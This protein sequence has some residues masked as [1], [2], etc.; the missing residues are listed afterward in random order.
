MCVMLLYEHIFITGGLEMIIVVAHTKGGVG[1][2]TIAW[3]IATALKDHYTIE[4]IDLDFQRTLTY[5]NQYRENPLEVKQIMDIKEFKKYASQDTNEK[6]S[7]VD[8]GGFDSD[9]NRTAILLADVVIT[10]VS[11]AGTELL[12]LIRFEKIIKEMSD[13]IGESIEIKIL[14]NNISPQK[15]KL[16]EL[17]E[18]IN[19]KDNFSLF[20]T[21]L[22]SRADY[23][24]AIDEGLG[25]I[26]YKPTSKA[27]EEMKQFIN[28][29][30]SIIKDTINEE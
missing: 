28:E 14:L 5:I 8:V 16:D 30:E 29:I 7:I 4:L 19:N 1:K 10:P 9:V 2:S 27:G 24:K 15:K 25:V 13:L 20:Q 18:Y 26:E 11:D 17:I 12:G 21:V 3:N 6:I 23:G 22:R